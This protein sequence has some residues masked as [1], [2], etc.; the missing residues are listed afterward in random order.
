MYKIWFFLLLMPFFAIADV[1]PYEYVFPIKVEFQ[2]GK[3][4][5]YW[6]SLAQ[7]DEI[8]RILFKTNLESVPDSNL[9]FPGEIDWKDSI[10]VSQQYFYAPDSA[11]FLAEEYLRLKAIK[12]IRNA[13]SD[14]C[15]IAGIWVNPWLDKEASNLLKTKKPILL[16]R[17]V[18]EQD[19]VYNAVHVYVFDKSIDIRKIEKVLLNL[20]YEYKN[21]EYIRNALRDHK[22]VIIDAVSP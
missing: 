6:T 8:A 9:L 7:N 17:I 16:K 4:K 19:V 11:R 3:S 15:P 2:N 10:R 21:N 14:S 5:I 12:K 18:F 13:S 1:T 20:M 22:L